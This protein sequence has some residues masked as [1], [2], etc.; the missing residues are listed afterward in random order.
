MSS[1]DY[2]V[3]IERMIDDGTAGTIKVITYRARE[4]VARFA[5]AVIFLGLIPFG[6]RMII[7]IFTRG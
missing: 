6:A 1:G 2:R 5:M 7:E 3:H 4:R